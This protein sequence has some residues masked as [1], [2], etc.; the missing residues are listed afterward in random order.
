MEGVVGTAG[1]PIDFS[2]HFDVGHGEAPL[3]AEAAPALNLGFVGEGMAE[4]AFEGWADV[5]SPA[6]SVRGRR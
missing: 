1:E 5:A 4:S 3:C 6:A 2:E